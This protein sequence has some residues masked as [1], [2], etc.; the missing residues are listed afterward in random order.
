[1]TQ[2]SAITRLACTVAGIALTL[3]MLSPAAHAQQWFGAASL[4]ADHYR[5]ASVLL[6]DGSVLVVG[7][8][9]SASAGS[10]ACERVDPLTNTVRSAA[11]MRVA[12]AWH[13]AVLLRDGTVLAIGGYTTNALNDCEVYDPVQDR[14][15][16][17]QSMRT[18]RARAVVTLLPD[19]N[20]LICGG[21]TIGGGTT[22]TCEV[23]NPIT[24]TWHDAAPMTYPRSSHAGVLLPNGKVLIVSGYPYVQQ[25]ELYDYR[26]NRWAS[27]AQ[28]PPFPRGEHALT[29]L[30]DGKVLL[31]SGWGGTQGMLRDCALYDYVSNTWAA[32]GSVLEARAAHRTILLPSGDV[33]AIEGH[34]ATTPGNDQS[35]FSLSTC[36]IY[37][38]STGTWSAG[39]SLPIRQSYFASTLLPTGQIWSGAGGQRVNS[40]DP[41]LFH[42]AS[43]LLDAAVPRLLGGSPAASANA[44]PASV[45]LPDGT[46][47]VFGGVASCGAPYAAAPTQR[48]S[49][50]TNSW[51]TPAFALPGLRWQ[52][53]TLLPDSAGT[54]VV[55]GGIDGATPSNRTFLVRTTSGTTVPGGAMARARWDHSATLLQNG[56]LLIIGGTADTTTPGIA[57]TERFNGTQW[58]TLAPLP[59]PRFRH[60]ATLLGDGRVLIAGGSTP[61]PTSGCWIFNYQCGNWLPVASMNNAR[62]R[63]TATRLPNGNI[64]VTG[65]VAGGSAP[66]A[67]CELYDAAANVWLPVGSMNTPRARHTATLLPT[68]DV[69]VTGGIGADGQSTA[70]A[71]LF[72]HVTL[73]WQPFAA[74]SAPRHNHAAALLPDGSVGIVGGVS[75]TNAGGCS[76]PTAFER[77]YPD[78]GFAE[79]SRPVISN[80]SASIAPAGAD[81]VLRIHLSGQGFCANNGTRATEGSTGDYNN[82]PVNYPVVQ[83]RRIGGSRYDDDFLTYL[84]FD[85]ANQQQWSDSG[86]YVMLSLG[87]A[88]KRV[89]PA[90]WYAVT[91]SANGIPSV[92]RYMN[93]VYGDDSG[94]ILNASG[95][96]DAT[97]CAG[98]TVTLHA[99]GGTT[100]NWSPAAGLSCTNCPSPAA[101]PENTTTYTVTISNGA[102][103][104]VVD[105]VTVNVNECSDSTEDITEYLPTRC[106]GHTERCAIGFYN[107]VHSDSA[108]KIS[109]SGAQADDYTLDTTLPFPL[110]PTR[111]IFIPIIHRWTVP[112]RHQTYMT[113]ETSSGI[114]YRIGI[115]TVTDQ[116]ITPVL[117]ASAFHLGEHTGLYDTCFV[118]RNT[119]YT[120]LNLNDTAWITNGAH[121]TLVS[122][123]LPVNVDRGDSVILCIHGDGLVPDSHGTMTLGGSVMDSCRVGRCIAQ[124]IDI[125]AKP[126]GQS[127]A[128]QRFDAEAMQIRCSPVPAHDR[129]Q[130]DF[131][132]LSPGPVRVR[133]IDLQGNVAAAPIDA[134]MPAGGYRFEI[135][136][137]GL[138]SGT[139]LVRVEQ[140]AGSGQRLIQ[141]VQ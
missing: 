8:T 32:T 102:G 26:T 53:A 95:G 54:V 34:D 28:L 127:L 24:R 7:G 22:N 68:G 107:R 69:L 77:L 125:D 141:I 38:P 85:A 19:G 63:H 110:P 123:H 129:L 81:L 104:S 136:T 27:A 140:Q 13:S 4:A 101:S 70:S 59:S 12:R 86:T 109:F 117:S 82:S 137:Q 41:L 114:T 33:I 116:T 15:T 9:S 119:Y 16:P 135:E 118:V 40:N 46:L 18:A 30:P 73:Q 42:R 72:N 84:P 131:T 88:G 31:T 71:E 99:S 29:L 134:A 5:T 39:P 56:D 94:S 3:A 67:T 49:S 1:M 35:C 115:I 87:A 23:Y 78:Y 106:A 55:A 90:G 76:L 111:T 96:P 105:S 97:L 20:V 57:T 61:S 2:H 79:R 66:L 62:A 52:T 80:L 43:T 83:V 128:V 44:S 120:T 126:G 132:V 14:W 91:V 10:T 11:S 25:S 100:Y 6:Q 51:S 21:L 58:D 75:Y 45:L 130:L 60:T 65:G 124:A 64:L 89:L 93:I 121:Y 17:V 122:P 37:S 98:D 36:E 50:T 138:A 103:C 133:L 92:A 139:Y 48:F 112:G 47:G 74:M 108:V 113:L